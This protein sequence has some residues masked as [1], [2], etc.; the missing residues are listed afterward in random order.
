MRRSGETR[1]ERLRRDLQ[2]D[3]EGKINGSKYQ[4]I[5][6]QNPTSSAETLQMQRTFTFHLQINKAA[7][8]PKHARGSGPVRSESR[9]K[10][11]PRCVWR[12]EEDGVQDTPAH[13]TERMKNGRI[14]LSEDAPH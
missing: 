3:L 13:L 14:L 7:A 8:S 2:L 1:S 5:L 12:P 9:P 11:S 4:T 6:E 10:S